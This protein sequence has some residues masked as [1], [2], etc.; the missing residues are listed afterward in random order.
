[1][2]TANSHEI[3][4]ELPVKEAFLLF[5][6]MGEELWVPGWRPRYLLPP[7]GK[8][9]E[10]MVFTTGEGGEATIWACLKFTPE[11]HSVRYLRVTP[12]SRV[13]IVDVAC[14]GEGEEATVVRVAYTYVPLSP[15]GEEFIATAASPERFRADIGA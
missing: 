9:A 1:M 4:V 3:R 10:E 15:A 6:P 8:T 5:T 13:A 7:S 14:R 11:R 2:T 12:G